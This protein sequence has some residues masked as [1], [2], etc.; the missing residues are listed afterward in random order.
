MPDLLAKCHGKLRA[1]TAQGRTLAALFVGPSGCG[2]SSA[3]AVLVLRALAEFVHSEGR[4]FASVV[5]L[6]WCKA[7]ELSAAEKRHPLGAGEPELVTRARTCGLLV[8]DDIRADS[9]PVLLFHVLSHRYDACLPTIATS[10]LGSKNLT[11][12]LRASGVRRLTEQHVP[13]CPVLV[14]DCHPPAKS[15][16]TKTDPAKPRPRGR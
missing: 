14:V 2:K 16:S 13:D 11:A 10:E 3:A 7:H 5:E 1:H 4:L 8:L 15:E 12:L 9:D 6:A